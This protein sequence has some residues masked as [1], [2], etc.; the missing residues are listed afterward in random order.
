M[1]SRRRPSLA[2][3]RTLA[4][5]PR[6]FVTVLVFCLVTAVTA[7]TLF[8]TRTGKVAASSSAQNGDAGQN[9]TSPAAAQ[10]QDDAPK[11]LS[12]EVLDQIAAM[13]QEKD[14]ARLNR[15]S[16][17]RNYCKPLK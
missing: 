4:G 1:K 6:L 11:T 16:S 14:H 17:I 15:T 2:P 12:A 13:Q 7:T 8:P 3:L 9:K 10:Q 5:L